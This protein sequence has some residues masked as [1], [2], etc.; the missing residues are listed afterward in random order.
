MTKSELLKL[1]SGSRIVTMGYTSKSDRV[2]HK[3]LETLNIPFINE[4]KFIDINNIEYE[5]RDNKINELL[6][7]KIND[8]DLNSIIIN[9]NNISNNNYRLNFEQLLRLNNNI[10]IT[11][12]LNTNIRSVT[13]NF[14]D[15]VTCFSNNSL[16][17]ISD[18]V[19]IFD[20]NGINIIKNRHG[21][22]ESK[23]IQYEDIW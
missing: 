13:D 1:L 20:E 4:Y 19:L 11:S 22:N 21:F 6:S 14:N 5:I 7:N 18:L 15:N 9:S 12:M 8:S 17:R 10:I 23:S 3:Y 2:L 16:L